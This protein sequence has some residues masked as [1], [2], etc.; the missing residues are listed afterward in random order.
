MD[1]A[2]RV[3]DGLLKRSNERYVMP[4]HIAI[5]Y[6]GLG[7]RKNALL[8]LEKSF[9]EQDAKIVFLKTDHIWDDLRSETR[10]IELMKKMD[11]E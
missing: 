2:R 1:E 10:F 9:S 7:D 5:A 11:L 8:W 6:M 3:L 4:Y